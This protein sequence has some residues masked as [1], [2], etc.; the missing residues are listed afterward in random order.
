M[1]GTIHV[2]RAAT[3]DLCLKKQQ[4]TS[5]NTLAAAAVLSIINGCHDALEEIN[6]CSLPAIFR[7]SASVGLRN[8]NEQYH[9]E[10]GKT[11]A[12]LRASKQRRDNKS[13]GP[14][15]PRSNPFGP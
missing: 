10:V 15:F 8:T 7:D 6:S 2:E 13:L 12:V 5:L 9:A 1:Y 3:A 4:Q 11:D 14:R